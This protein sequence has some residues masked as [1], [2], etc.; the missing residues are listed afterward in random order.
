M[1]IVRRIARKEGVM[2]VGREQKKVMG[3]DMIKKHIA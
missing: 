1:K 2:G 3:V